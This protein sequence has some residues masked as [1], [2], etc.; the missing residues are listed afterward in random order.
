M[1]S[2]IEEIV[3]ECRF[4]FKVQVKPLKRGEI[5]RVLVENMGYSFDG[6]CSFVLRKP[7]TYCYPPEFKFYPKVGTSKEEHLNQFKDQLK[8]LLTEGVEKMPEGSNTKV[9]LCYREEDPLLISVVFM[10]TKLQILA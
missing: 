3:Q 7:H 2:R 10:P 8:N 5:G 4:P 1:G 9:V 6:E